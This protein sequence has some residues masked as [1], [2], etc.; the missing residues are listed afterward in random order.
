[1]N[2]STRHNSGVTADKVHNAGLK[3]PALRRDDEAEEFLLAGAEEIAGGLGEVEFAFHVIDAD[4]IDFDPALL[5]EALGFAAG[6]RSFHLDKNCREAFEAVDW[7]RHF[8]NIPRG[9]A[10]AEDAVPFFAGGA[11]G[12]FAVEP[13]DDIVSQLHLGFLRVQDAGENF[14]AEADDRWPSKIGEQLVV[15]PH[16]LV[17]NR[18]QL[19]DHFAGRL[20]DPDVVAEALGHFA[21]ATESNEDGHGQRD[22]AA[23]AVFA[24]D[25]AM[26][27]HVEL[28]FGGA[29][30]DIGFEHD[31]VIGGEQRV[32]QL[33]NGDGLIFIEARAEI[34][35]FQ[36]AR[37]AIVAAETDHVVAG[38]F[39][40]PFAVVADLGFSLVENFVNLLEIGFRVGVDLFARKRRARFGLSG[41]I[42]N[43]RGKIADQENRG[44]THVLKVF[45]LPQDDG[46]AE[47]NIGRGGIDAK[48]DAQRLASFRGIFELGLQLVLANDFGGAFFQV[49]KLFVN[50]LERRSH[51]IVSGE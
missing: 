8:G 39:A 23:L 10:F 44:V 22:L 21:F 15:G 24:L 18:H 13:G 38:H 19:A 50:G 37:E 27:E 32:K 48:I 14:F 34:F 40:E 7:E 12:E 47:M 5:D 33:V 43:H 9:F 26:D 16:Q 35:A 25:I 17:R 2:L 42:A 4:A 46:V 6:R 20:G 11:G 29:Q 41:G 28:L 30:L 1:M 31:G 51:L 49:R 3:T 45:Q 36:H